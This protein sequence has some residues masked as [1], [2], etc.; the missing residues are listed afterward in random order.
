[1]LAFFCACEKVI[2]MPASHNKTLS[3]GSFS[4]KREVSSASGNYLT[5]DSDRDRRG[6]GC[7]MS[8]SILSDRFFND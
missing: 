6:R 4:R 5:P 8:A 3:Q 2:A 7:R 1:M